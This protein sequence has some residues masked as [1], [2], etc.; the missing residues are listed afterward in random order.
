MEGKLKNVP[1]QQCFEELLAEYTVLCL[2]RYSKNDATAAASFSEHFHCKH[3]DSCK[4]LYWSNL[5][6][7]PQCF[8]TI[9]NK[10]KTFD[11]MTPCRCVFSVRQTNYT[12]VNKIYEMIN[13]P[14]R[15]KRLLL[16]SS[17][18]KRMRKGPCDVLRLSL[19][20]AHYALRVPDCILLFFFITECASGFSLQML[21]RV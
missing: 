4:Q 15:R 2:G 11:I 9:M 10:L 3:W 16:P 5:R 20:A 13:N 21:Q 18:L 7:L 1:C 17:R 8:G 14:S 6:L 19:T 12:L